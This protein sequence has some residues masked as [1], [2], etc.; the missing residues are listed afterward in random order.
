MNFS[1]SDLDKGTLIHKCLEDLY[2]PYLMKILNLNHID[3]IISSVEKILNKN[4]KKP[5]KFKT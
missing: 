3:K 2:R 4:I 1:V 5:D